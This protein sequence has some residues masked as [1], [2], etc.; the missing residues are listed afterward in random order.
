MVTGQ[1]NIS[2]TLPSSMATL[3]EFEC[4]VPVGGYTV[5]TFDERKFVGASSDWIDDV[6]PEVDATEDEQYLLSKWG[7]GIVPVSDPALPAGFEPEVREILEPQSEEFRLY[8]S[9]H[10]VPSSHFK[11]FNFFDEVPKRHLKRFS[12]FDEAAT[13]YIEFANT[14]DPFDAENAKALANRFGPLNA[15]RGPEYVDQWTLSIIEMHAALTRWEK[16]KTTGDFCQLIRFV[17]R[18]W[19]VKSKSGRFFESEVDRIDTSI[20]LRA[21]PLSGAPKLCIRPTTL[22][23]ALWTQLALAIDGRQSLRSC[24]ECKRWFAIES[25]RGRSDKEYCSDACRM[26]AYRKRKGEALAKRAKKGKTRRRSQ[27]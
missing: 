1:H 15:G 13:P 8:R 20:S 26:R 14:P 2:V 12:L 22:L 10:K 3:L 6:P 25:N 11:S 23:N 27:R 19:A 17:S 24:I 16:A 7:V 4:R 9:F 21:D 18:Q 5:M